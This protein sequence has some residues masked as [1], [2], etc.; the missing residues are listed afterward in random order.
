M[1]RK[2]L[3]T[4]LTFSSGVLHRTKIFT[5]DYRYTANFVDA[6]SVDEIVLIDITDPAAES[7][8]EFHGVVRKFA[9]KC[10][11]PLSVGGGVRELDDVRELLGIGADKIIVGELAHSDPGIVS[12]IARKYG[13]QCVV[14]ALDARLG[15]DGRHHVYVDH[16]RRPVGATAQEWAAHLERI[17]A[18]EVLATSID[19]DGSLEGYDLVLAKTVSQAI[20][21][22]V[23]IA[24]GAGNWD[25]FVQAFNQ[26]GVDAV[27]TAN[28]YHFTESAIRSAKS[29]MRKAGILVR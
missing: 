10:R 22:P 15:D 3:I 2:R 1:L 19:R 26:A 9:E 20:S 27:S 4:V 5:P 12:E 7:R 16:G 25:H 28:I 6:W 11:V 21:V 13:S 23:I 24:G 29:F 8:E 18:G 14:G 17:G